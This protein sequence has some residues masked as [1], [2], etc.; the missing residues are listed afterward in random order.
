MIASLLIPLL[1]AARAA[2][3]FV[4]D[5]V[6][7]KKFDLAPHLHKDVVVVSFFATWCT[8]CQAELPA[9]QAMQDA[10]A[11]DGLQVVV[12]SVDDPKSV[13][14]VKPLVREHHWTFPVLLD[15]DTKVVSTWN[16]KKTVPFT[17]VIDRDGNVAWEHM[18]YKSGEEKTLEDEVTKLLAAPK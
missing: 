9:L 2:T 17:A 7:G 4:L 13:S 1:A 6:D 8:P 3:P 18:G 11:N 16:P 5:D 10:H 12:I 14:G 15:T